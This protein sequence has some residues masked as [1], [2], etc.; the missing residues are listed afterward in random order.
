[1][2]AS[3]PGGH[4]ISGA[5]AAAP[6]R[7]W[8]RKTAALAISR[9]L[10]TGGR[11]VSIRGPCACAGNDSVYVA[12]PG[13]WRP[14]AWRPDLRVQRSRLARGRASAPPGNRNA[15][16]PQA[17]H[18][19]GPRRRAG[20]ERD[21]PVAAQHPVPGQRRIVAAGKEL[22]HPARAPGKPGAAGDLAV[23]CD[24]AARDRA[25][26]GEDA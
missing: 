18:L 6:S 8:S 17:P 16:G 9:P 21:P 11:L 19:L 13:R 7:L 2:N 15:F 23:A 22:R 25:N 12:R 26:G 20:R 5:K 3:T 4:S 10:V 24:L 1:M 14:L